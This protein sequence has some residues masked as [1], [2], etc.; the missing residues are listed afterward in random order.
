MAL[1]IFRDYIM[2]RIV[3]FEIGADDIK[4]AVEFY[5]EMFG[6]RIENREGAWKIS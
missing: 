5:R 1:T 3:H 4:R 6:W 2:N